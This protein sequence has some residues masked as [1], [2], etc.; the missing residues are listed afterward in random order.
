MK[1]ACARIIRVRPRSLSVYK[2][3][4]TWQAART[5]STKR[6]FAGQATVRWLDTPE[7]MEVEMTRGAADGKKR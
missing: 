6:R 7:A 2:A 3:S 1:Q 5:R 4:D